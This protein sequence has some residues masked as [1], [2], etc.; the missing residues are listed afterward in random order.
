MTRFCS[1]RP[2]VPASQPNPVR[3]RLDARLTAVTLNPLAPAQRRPRSAGALCAFL[4]IFLVGFTYFYAL[5]ARLANVADRG[6]P[7]DG[8]IERRFEI[9][10]PARAE[11]T[12]FELGDARAGIFR[13]QEA[14]IAAREI[15]LR[16]SQ[17]E[18]VPGVADRAGDVRFL[19]DL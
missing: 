9:E 8:E 11:N 14:A 5:V 2:N 17:L 4:I 19:P 16:P 13:E 7:E 18:A 15:P 6:A 3:G 1:R 12:F 10:V